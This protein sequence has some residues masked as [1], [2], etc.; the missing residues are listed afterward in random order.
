MIKTIISIAITA[1]LIFTI[2]IFEHHDIQSAFTLFESALQSLY[3]KTEENVATYD[4]ATAVQTLW[5]K[6]KETLHIWIPHTA[7][8]EVDYQ[9][10]DAVGCLYVQ[11]YEN[12]LP[13]IEVLLGMC[14][15]IP[16]SYTFRP[17]NIL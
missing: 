9:L 5:E 6:E 11:D 10:Y 2:C 15:N 14:E 1:A 13:K 8:Q 3:K 7:I 4:D 16:S 12:A 17:E